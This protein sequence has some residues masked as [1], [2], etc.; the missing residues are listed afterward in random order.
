MIDLRN[1]SSFMGWNSRVVIPGERQTARPTGN[2]SSRPDSSASRAARTRPFRCWRYANRLLT[3]RQQQ[4]ASPYEDDAELQ[5]PRP[6]EPCRHAQQ[7]P[8]H[9]SAKCKR[10]LTARQQHLDLF[11]ELD[12]EVQPPRSR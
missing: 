5:S 2:G 3:A 11:Y 7:L 8:G 4:L 12:A 6:N 10:F 1:V 9:L